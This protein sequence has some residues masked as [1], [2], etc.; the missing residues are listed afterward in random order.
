MFGK[1]KL[2]DGVVKLSYQPRTAVDVIFNPPKLP[3]P[4][5]RPDKPAVRPAPKRGR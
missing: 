3:A 4:P 5:K 1:K 2:D